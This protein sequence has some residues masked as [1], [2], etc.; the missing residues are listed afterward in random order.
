MTDLTTILTLIKELWIILPAA[1]LVPF[2]TFFLG[3][4]GSNKDRKLKY[5]TFIDIDEIV[6]NY[7]LKNLPDVKN[8]TK[9]IIPEEY[10]GLEKEVDA[11]I[12]RNELISTKF[13]FLKIK[14][15]GESIVTSGWISIKMR[16]TTGKERWSLSTSLPIIS[17]DEEIYLPTDRLDKLNVE[18]YL[19]E[20]KIKYQTQ[21]GE[22]LIFKSTRRKNKGNETV[23]K[24]SHSV[25]RFLLFSYDIQNSKGKNAEWIF[26]NNEKDKDKDKDKE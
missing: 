5:R 16:S 21:V 17:K 26:L 12:K 2:I 15:L 1:L 11:R 14:P 6:A 7:K 18:Y 19:E 10:K 8:G 20:I 9:L 25:K 23:V 13:N 4:L 24:D 22:K 3:R